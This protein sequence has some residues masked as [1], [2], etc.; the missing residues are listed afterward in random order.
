[1][2]AQCCPDGE[3]QDRMM[4]EIATLADMIEEGMVH[5]KTVSALTADA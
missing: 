2:S 4:L 3:L 1:M 5:P